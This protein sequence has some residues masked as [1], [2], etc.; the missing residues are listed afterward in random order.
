[1][2]LADFILANVEPILV[3]WERFARGIWP[4]PATDPKTLRDHAEAILRATVPDMKSAQSDAQQTAKSKGGE[5]SAGPG[6]RV[7]AASAQHGADRVA[8][9]FELSA[10]VAEYRALRASVLRLWRRSTPTPD[11]NDI[12]DVTRFNESIDQSLAEAVG[13]FAA[14]VERNLGVLADEKAARAGAEQANNAKD[15]FLAILSHELR[16][17][18]SAIAGWVSILRQGNSSD[19]DLAEGLEVIDRNTRAQTQ[20]I[21]DILDVS[22]IVSGKMSLD[23]R[24]CSLSEVVAASVDAARIAAAA[25]GVALRVTVDPSARTDECDAARMEQVVSNLLANALKFTPGGGRV[26][27]QLSRGPSDIRIEVRDTG[28]GIEPQHLA[29]I[30]DRFRQAD[31]STRRRAGGL[32]LGLSIVKHLVEAH[33]GTVRASSAGRGQGANFT[34]TLPGQSAS[35]DAKGDVAESPDDLEA[36]TDS[37]AKRFPPVRLDGLR[38]MVVDDEPDALR[39]LVKVLGKVGAVVTAA[40]SATQAIAELPNARPEVLVGDI[41]MPDM[42]GFDMIRKMRALG[43]HPRD[44]P[45]VALTAFVQKEDQRKVL[46]AGFQVHVPKP[47]NPHDLICVIASLAG[48][49]SP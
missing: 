47:V 27:V 16:T 5:G 4:G 20:L 38:V 42:D 15:T 19:A 21:E 13:G 11:Q 32:G 6:D 24:P 17:P 45:A 36:T 39:M 29:H 12:E 37:D 22:R 49:T 26:D 7:D 48:R 25:R 9:G 28:E 34:V 44:L 23:I 3:E 31:S 35:S 10:L 8:N 40:P 33:G 2:R 41:G 1:M 18:L 43:H 30:F 46:L 14:T